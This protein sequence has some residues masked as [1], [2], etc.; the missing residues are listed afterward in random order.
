MGE[1]LH[2]IARRHTDAVA[3]MLAWA[4][5][6]PITYVVEVTDDTAAL[7]YPYLVLYPDA[8]TALRS[9]LGAQSGV[10]RFPFQVTAV[11]RDRVETLAALDRARE[12]LVD[13]RPAVAGRSCGPVSQ[14]VSQPVRQDPTERDPTS[15]RPLFYA[16]AVFA[17]T[18]TPSQ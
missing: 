8:G 16:V 5:G 6:Q 14:T 15:G 1:D 4:D 7:V 17:V 12:A 18:S 10:Y 3:T 2:D 9:T 13:Q 11:G